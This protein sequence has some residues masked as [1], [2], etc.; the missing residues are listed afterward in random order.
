MVYIIVIIGLLILSI[1]YDNINNYRKS[2]LLRVVVFLVFVSIPG[3]SFEIG[4]DIMYSY[5][6]WF[7]NQLPLI[8]SVKLDQTGWE[9]L[10]VIYSS[11]FKTL[12]DNWFLYYF[13]I[14]IFVNYTIFKFLNICFKD[15]FFLS[16][17]FY[18]LLFYYDINFESLRQ[19]MAM[20]IFLLSWRSLQNRN[21][22]TYI[23]LCLIASGS[24]YS[25]LITLIIPFL[26]KI[27]FDKK[28]F[29]II[30]VLLLLGS[31][32]N[33]YFFNIA[34]SF[35]ILGGESFERLLYTYVESQDSVSMLNI[36]GLISQFLIKVIPIIIIGI[37]FQKCEKNTLFVPILYVFSVFSVLTMFVPYLFRYSYFFSI[38]VSGCYSKFLKGKMPLANVLTKSIIIILFIVSCLQFYNMQDS[39]GTKSW[40]RFYPY[41]SIFN[42]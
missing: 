38:I 33:R 2:G 20:G 36:F 3:F 26:R 19:S 25:A 31:L 16:L 37:S 42:K 17:L 23:P 34:T 11:L 13:S 35:F 9:P 6:P 8:S 7:E 15:C 4:S 39:F 12:C 30:V 24:H 40:E 5:K 41:T 14:I 18:F 21:W 28:G 29:L 22:K 27:S 1:N 10:F 32:I